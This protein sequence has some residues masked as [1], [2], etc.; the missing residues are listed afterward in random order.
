MELRELT[1]ND[2][3]ELLKITCHP[4]VIKYTP[5]VIQDRDTLVSWLKNK[6]ST[7]REYMILL[8]E[9]VIGECSLDEKS[10]DIGIMLYPEYWRQ[11]Y[12][13]A[14][15]KQLLQMAEDAGL[16]EVSAQ[17][18]RRNEACIALLEGV[19]FVRCGMGWSL[20]EDVLEKP[21]NDL[22][23]ILVFK[24]SLGKESGGK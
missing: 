24:R 9:R 20:S 22:Q 12:G 3:E 4:E 1:Q 6:P 5:N 15:V 2:V 23:E 21:L 19:D 17:T 10:G 14:A 7:D 18:D 16:D 8:D 11:G 13:T